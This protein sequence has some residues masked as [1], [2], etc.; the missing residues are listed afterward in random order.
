VTLEIRA[1]RP[2]EQEET[3]QVTALAYRE[4]APD[5]ASPNADYLRRV[6]DVATRVGHGLVLGAFRDGRVIGS[7]TVELSDRIPGGHP[8]PPLEPDQ[9][10][11]RMLGIHPEERGRGVGRA[12]MDAVVEAARTAGKRRLTLETTVAMRAAQGLYGSM[13]FRRGPDQVYDDG[14]RLRTYELPL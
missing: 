4:F 11:V 7:V 14:F 12:L 13:G 6:A 5:E 9:A 8:R 10:H 2:E 1:V 3:G